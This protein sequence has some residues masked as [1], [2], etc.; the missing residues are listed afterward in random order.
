MTGREPGRVYRAVE[1]RRGALPGESGDLL[2]LVRLLVNCADE[3]APGIGL[4]GEASPSK[5]VRE[6][7]EERRSAHPG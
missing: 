2:E 4:G 3:A 6:A 1:T 7:L 5:V